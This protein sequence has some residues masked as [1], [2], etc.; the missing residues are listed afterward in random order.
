MGIKEHMSH[1]IRL[2][3]SVNQEEDHLAEEHGFVHGVRLDERSR[4]WLGADRPASNELRSYLENLDDTTIVKIQALI[5]AG[6][7][8][9][10]IQEIV[11]DALQNPDSKEEIVQAIME[12]RGAY[13]VYFMKVLEKADCEGLDLDSL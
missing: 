13:E 8:K 4:G 1:L 3:I 2:N 5:E 6:R 12:K 10:P 11:S 9:E 7:D